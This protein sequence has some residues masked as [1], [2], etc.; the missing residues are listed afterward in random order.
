MP[1]KIHFS[2]YTNN[3]CISIGYVDIKLRE[4]LARLVTLVDS[5]LAC[6]V[7]VWFSSL[8]NL[9]WWRLI[10][11]RYIWYVVFEHTIVDPD[12]VRQINERMLAVWTPSTFCRDALV[13]GGVTIPVHVVPHGVDPGEFAPMDRPARDTYTFFW[14]G[15]NLEK[16]RKQGWVVQRA[17]EELDLPDARL[18]LKTVP[19]PG[20]AM[21]MKLDRGRVHQIASWAKPHQIAELD[22]RADAF[23]WPTR[24]EGFGLIP[25]EK[26]ATGL[27]CI[28]T[29][30]SGP[31]DYLRDDI[32]LPLRRYGMQESIYGPERGQDALV[33]P[34]ELKEKMLWC[35]EHREEAA[36]IGRAASFYVRSCWT[37]DGLVFRALQ[38]AL[39]DL[40]A[41]LKGAA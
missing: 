2:S 4:Q 35:Y 25:L 32:A 30:W 36:Q 19:W 28:V 15:T 34:E 9:P 29:D 11:E 18:I 5:P 13:S 21:D 26:M 3:P 40:G 16:D 1:L 23:V 24:A 22:M 27:P 37:W 41:S 20:G 14:Q 31:R 12:Q 6:D 39:K 33:D 10:P 17:F 7:E 38:D 8:A